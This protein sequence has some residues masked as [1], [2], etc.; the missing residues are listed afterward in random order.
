MKFLNVIKLIPF[1][2]T[3][4]EKVL[5]SFQQSIDALDKIAAQTSEKITGIENQIMDLEADIR[6]KIASLNRLK[7]EQAAELGRANAV[8]E[9]LSKLIAIK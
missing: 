9:N 6:V 5:E 8:K 4:T 2:L 1:A 3:T 7:K